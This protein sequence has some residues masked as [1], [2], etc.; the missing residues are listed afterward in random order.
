MKYNLNPSF[1]A[2]HIYGNTYLVGSKIEKQFEIELDESTKK[3]LSLFKEPITIEYAINFMSNEIESAD[4]EEI[5]KWAISET[6]IVQDFNEKLKEEENYNPLYDRQIRLFEEISPGNGFNAQRKLSN[7]RVTLIGAGGTGCYILYTLAAMGVGFV[8]V[9]DYDTVQIS[10]LSRQ[11]I[12][13]KDDIGKLKINCAKERIQQ[14]N[15]E[16]NYEY[17]NK[18]ITSKLDVEEII[19][20]TDICILTADT[21]RKIIKSMINDVCVIQGTPYIYGGS[22]VDSITVGPLVIPGKTKDISAITSKTSSV[23]DDFTKSFN[24]SFVS[25][26]IDPYNAL[27]ASYTALEC[28][29]YLT[30]FSSPVL[31]NKIMFINLSNYEITIIN[32]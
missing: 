31:I 5:I 4:I 1:L 20:N 6:I 12:Y 25:T 14:L 15:P 9:V 28:V 3:L 23:E 13:T 26:L 18:R 22:N 16:L 29:K 7:S 27:A 19:N 30:G 8:R 10:N 2:Y 24:E 32:I 17:I 21:P 11:I